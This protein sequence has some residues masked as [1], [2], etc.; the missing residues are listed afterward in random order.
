MCSAA[1]PVPDEIAEAWPAPA[2]P[3]LFGSGVRSRRNAAT[4]SEGMAT[5][6]TARSARTSALRT[7]RGRP[8]DTRRVI[9]RHGGPLSQA[10][11]ERNRYQDPKKDGGSGASV[12]AK[13]NLSRSESADFAPN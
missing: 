1:L 5:A 2:P 4:A 3:T 6:P 7:G 9:G 10:R 12:L 11:A 13:R 8:G